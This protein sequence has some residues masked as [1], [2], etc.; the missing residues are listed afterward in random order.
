M[1]ASGMSRAGRFAGR[2]IESRLNPAAR[3]CVSWLDGGVERFRRGYC[4]HEG[5][6]VSTG[7]EGVVAMRKPGLVFVGAIVFLMGLVFTLQG[8]GLLKGSSMSDT[9]FWSVAGPVIMLVGFAVA[10]AGFRT[11]AR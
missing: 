9:T 10:A 8:V 5:P 11:K 7:F 6:L 4:C 2:I 1:T 3:L